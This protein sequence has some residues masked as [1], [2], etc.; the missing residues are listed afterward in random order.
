[1]GKSE[2]SHEGLF[3]FVLVLGLAFRGTR[4][5]DEDE[6]EDENWFT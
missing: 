4:G 1:V 6:D 2:A 5:E 3:R